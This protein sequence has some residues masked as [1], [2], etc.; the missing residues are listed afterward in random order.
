M[1]MTFFFQMN[2]IG[3]FSGVVSGYAG[4]YGPA[5]PG[6]TLIENEGINF[7]AISLNFPCPT[8]YQNSQPET[9]WSP[10][11]FL[12]LSLSLLHYTA[13]IAAITIHS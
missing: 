1:Y 3:I 8:A 12:S 11:L 7:P 9:D 6:G 13:A 4:A 10:C 5:K 2:L